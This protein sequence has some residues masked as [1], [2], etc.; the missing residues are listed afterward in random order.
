[1]SGRSNG[2]SF[3]AQMFFPG[4]SANDADSGGAGL[5]PARTSL[6]DEC[7]NEEENAVV[8]GRSGEWTFD[9]SDNGPG[10]DGRA[11][12][13]L[14]SGDGLDGEDAK[15]LGGI[16]DRAKPGEVP[17]VGPEGGGP[18]GSRKGEEPIRWTGG[19]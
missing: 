19:D 6:I 9:L 17:P 4:P 16:G 12:N 2:V 18:M 14:D 5:V 8:G 11:E 13:E 10:T 15:A 3:L 1:M 7:E